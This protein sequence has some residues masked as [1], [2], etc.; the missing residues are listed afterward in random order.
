MKTNRR[1]VVVLMAGLFG[2]PA[3]MA[4]EA[5]PGTQAVRATATQSY[6]QLPMSFEANQ[7]QAEREARFLARGQGY[8][9]YLTATEA[10]LVTAPRPG[11]ARGTLRPLGS[12]LRTR[13]VG[14]NPTPRLK[15]EGELIGKVNYLH[16]NDRS[17]WR[18]NIPTYARVRYES[19]YPGTDLV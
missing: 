3:L 1:A 4:Q 15:A 14:A 10:V 19:V 16:G 12:V 18:T 2:P 8:S 9:L 17:R 7:G 6:G 11:A 5:G 13:L